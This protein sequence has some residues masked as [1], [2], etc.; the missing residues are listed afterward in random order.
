MKG[1]FDILSKSDDSSLSAKS[2]DNTAIES[3]LDDDAATAGFEAAATDCYQAL[4]GGDESGF[5]DALQSAI[6]MLK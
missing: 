3:S 6:E 4:K 2:G 5:R 1:L